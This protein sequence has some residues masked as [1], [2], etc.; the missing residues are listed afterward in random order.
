MDS[1]L[2]ARVRVARLTALLLSIV[3]LLALTAPAHAAFPGQNGKIAFMGGT[4]EGD[5]FSVNADGSGLNNLTNTGNARI[6]SGPAWSPDGTKIAFAVNGALFG[7]RSAIYVMNADGSDATVLASSLDNVAIEPTWS[8]D[9]KRI[10]FGCGYICVINADGSGGVQLPGAGGFEPAWSPDGT[11]IVFVREVCDDEGCFDTD[12]WIMNAD[13]SGLMLLR[14]SGTRPS[15]SPDGLKIAFDDRANVWTM[16]ADGSGPVQIASD[17][18]SPAWSP[19]GEKIAFASRFL[20][21]GLYTASAD[22]S[23]QTPVITDI[24]GGSTDLR[25]VDWQPIPAPQRSD[26]NN[27]AKFCEADQGFLGESAFAQKYGANG[28]GANAYGQCVSANGG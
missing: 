20:H 12:L 28:N 10:A 6:E 5:I 14:H 1:K 16:N 26:F 8:P 19:D 17:R 25:T 7:T 24:A 3:A 2:K 9:G 15:W 21:G 18:V 27:A 22:G 23:G 13:G 11:R 4:P